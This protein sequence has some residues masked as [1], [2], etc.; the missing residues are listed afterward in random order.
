MRNT[1]KVP[2]K[3]TLPLVVI[4]VLIS[5]LS[6]QAVAGHRGDYAE[7][8][9]KHMAKELKLSEE[10]VTAIK[11]LK[12]NSAEKRSTAKEKRKEIKALMEADNVDA[13]ANLAAEQAKAKIYAKAENK[14]RMAAILDTEQLEQWQ[15]LR[16]EKHEKRKHRKHHGK[17]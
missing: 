6:L 16:E 12:E 2:L 4:G 14:Q 9:M 1:L 7:R 5:A 17:D 3:R 11:A 8:H 15:E 13:A 10:Q